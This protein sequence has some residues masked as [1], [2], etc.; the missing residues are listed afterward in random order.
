MLP[1]VYVPSPDVL[2]EADRRRFFATFAA[3]CECTIVELRECGAALV[4]ARCDA[5]LI[6][7]VS[8]R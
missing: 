1:T 6:K 3:T 8:E 2:A 4:C 7:R 5:P